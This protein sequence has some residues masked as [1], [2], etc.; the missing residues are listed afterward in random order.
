MFKHNPST[1]GR[2]IGPV[3]SAL[4]TSSLD[5]KTI[6]KRRQALCKGK[7]GTHLLKFKNCIYLFLYKILILKIKHK[8]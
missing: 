3:R 2:K 1:S 4:W 6:A 8:T 5:L 7:Q